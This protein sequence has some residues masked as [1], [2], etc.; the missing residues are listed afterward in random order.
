MQGM[1]TNSCGLCGYPIGTYCDGTEWSHDGDGMEPCKYGH[2]SCSTSGR[3]G[4]PCANEE[5]DDE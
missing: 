5:N 2:G 3:T 1:N 4:G